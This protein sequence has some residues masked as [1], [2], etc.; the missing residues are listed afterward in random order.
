[1][2]MSDKTQRITLRLTETQFAFVKSSADMVG[3]SPSEF[4]RQVV[5]VCMHTVEGVNKATAEAD[6]GDGQIPL[7]EIVGKAVE[8]R[9]ND[10][11][12]SNDSV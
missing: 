4:L 7:A 11:T 9:A 1:M 3:V 6:K 2:Y 8:G 5:N 10:K 12:D